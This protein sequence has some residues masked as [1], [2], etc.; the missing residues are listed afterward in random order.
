MKLINQNTFGIALILLAVTSC[1]HDPV[2]QEYPD[3]ASPSAEIEK[4]NQN[5]ETAH[6]NQV[7][8]LSPK[9]HE[10]AMDA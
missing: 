4:L 2:T 5:M 1:S 10:N 8:V 7:D 6:S 9:H 3:T